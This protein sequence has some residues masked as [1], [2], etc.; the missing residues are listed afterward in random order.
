LISSRL[1]GNVAIW[2]SARI[3]SSTA[4]T[5]AE[6]AKDPLSGLTRQTGCFF[7]Q[8]SLTAVTGQNLGLVLG[9]VSEVSF[10]EHR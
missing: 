9:N 8:A 3:S 10:E 6:R 2:A 1:A 5:K 4:S 7:D